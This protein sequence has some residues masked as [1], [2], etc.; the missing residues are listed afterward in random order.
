MEGEVTFSG[1]EK[2]YGNMVEIK[3]PNG[4]I[5]RYGHNAELKVKEGDY[6]DSG[7]VIALSGSSGRSTGPHLHFELRKGEFSLNPVK[8]I[9]RLNPG[10]L[11]DFSLILRFSKKMPM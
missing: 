5:S 1:W 3:H 4:M 8:M 6:V 11:S 9:D 2:G 10:L 7:A